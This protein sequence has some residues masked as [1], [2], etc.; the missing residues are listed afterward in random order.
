ME[1]VERHAVHVA[2]RVVVHVGAVRHAEA[3]S[4]VERQL[5]R[6]LEVVGEVEV[7]EEG[8]VV[9]VAVLVEVPPHVEARRD[10][11]VAPLD[12]REELV[13]LTEPARVAVGE[14][15]HD[16]AHVEVEAVEEGLHVA[17]ALV[18]DAHAAEAVRGLVAVDREVRPEA[19]LERA[20]L[21]VLAELEEH[22]LRG[23]PHGPVE[24]DLAAPHVRRVEG[25]L[26]REV[27]VLVENRLLGIVHRL[28]YGRVSGAHGTTHKGGGQR[29][30][31]PK[32]TECIVF[33]ARSIP[34]SGCFVTPEQ[35]ARCRFAACHAARNRV[36]SARLLQERRV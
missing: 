2:A 19:E 12:A 15:V 7:E 28:L 3:G 1:V 17:H 22:V 21:G 4:E 11:G 13:R 24:E 35:M 14:L 16:R 8:V 33:H 32:R 20:V 25:K 10:V 9:V 36:Q 26:R 5:V 34:Q 23:L 29:G 6:D 30:C 31:N 18:D 27:D